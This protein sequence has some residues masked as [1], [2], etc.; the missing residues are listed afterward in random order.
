MRGLAKIVN[1][2]RIIIIDKKAKNKSL[3]ERLGATPGVSE[4]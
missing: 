3:L 2:G 4:V 1:L